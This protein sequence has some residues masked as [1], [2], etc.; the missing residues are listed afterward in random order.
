MKNSP[1]IRHSVRNAA[2]ADRNAYKVKPCLQ[3]GNSQQEL[4]ICHRVLHVTTPSHEVALRKNMSDYEHRCRFACR[5]AR[6]HLALLRPIWTARAV[7]FTKSAPCLRA[8]RRLAPFPA[9]LRQSGAHWL[10]VAAA[11]IDLDGRPL[12]WVRTT[13]L[14]CTSPADYYCRSSCREGSQAS[15]MRHRR[16][17]LRPRHAI[18]QLGLSFC[19]TTRILRCLQIA[20]APQPPIDPYR[21]AIDGAS[22]C[23]RSPRYFVAAPNAASSCR[24]R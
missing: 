3:L 4:A 2:N 20:A 9:G 23:T 16:G 10:V 17:W 14:W 15:R 11:T 5:N 24:G 6:R 13:K 21:G 22:R 19:C 18:T 12:C 8:Y 1:S 7:L